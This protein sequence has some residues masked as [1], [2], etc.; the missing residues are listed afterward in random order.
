MW[1][2]PQLMFWG[3]LFFWALCVESPYG[4]AICTDRR[5]WLYCRRQVFV[6]PGRCSRLPHDQARWSKWFAGCPL[7]SLI[8]SFPPPPWMDRHEWIRTTVLILFYKIKKSY[9]SPVEK[10]LWSFGWMLVFFVFGAVKLHS[11][12]FIRMEFSLCYLLNWFKL[13]VVSFC[14]GPGKG[15]RCAKERFYFGEG[16]RRLF[17]RC[18]ADMGA[19]MIF[20]LKRFK[21]HQKDYPERPKWSRKGLWP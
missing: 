20:N 18:F 15:G 4:G 2:F 16:P 19:L 3:R 21:L 7:K 1:G 14:F 5:R 9:I 8:R 10:S 13:L 11:W 6:R 17:C 12:D